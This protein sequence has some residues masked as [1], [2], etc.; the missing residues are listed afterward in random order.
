VTED[1]F[2]EL[3]RR[4]L[5]DLDGV[6]EQAIGEQATR[7]C[8]EGLGR[9]VF[10]LVCPHQYGVWLLDEVEPILSPGQLPDRLGSSYRQAVE[11]EKFDADADV[12]RELLPWLADRWATVG[13]PDRLG[14]A[15]AIYE[16]PMVVRL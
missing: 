7:R 3:V 1:E 15:F 16:D 10:F 5:A 8:G 6:V 13:G 4:A 9:A 14:P 11:A 2:R 12:R